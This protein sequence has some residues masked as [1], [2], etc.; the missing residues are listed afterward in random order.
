MKKELLNPRVSVKLRKAESRQEWYIYIEIYPARV[1]GKPGKQ[2]VRKYI[3]RSITTPIW[4]KNQVARTSKGVISYKPKRDRNGIIMC[5]SAIDRESCVYADN[6]RSILQREYDFEDLYYYQFYRNQA[7]ETEDVVGYF[8]RIITER[9]GKKS[10]STVYNFN[11]VYALFKKFVGNKPLRF[12]E[13]D[14]NLVEDFKQYLLYAPKGGKLKGKISKNTASIYFIIFKTMLKQAFI[15]GHLQEDLCSKT[16]GIRGNETHR[17]YLTIEELN[18]LAKAP[19]PNSIIKRAALFSALTGM[20]HCDIK[21]MT[22][23]EIIKGK[24][25]I[26]INFT[27]KKTKGVEY[28]P[29]SMQAYSLCGKPSNPD[30]KV[31]K[32][33]PDPSWICHPLNKWLAASGITK[34]ITFHCFRHT[35]ATLQL[36]NGTDIYTVSKMLGH[37]N[38]KTTQIYTKI[39][40]EKKEQAA[41]AIQLDLDID[42]D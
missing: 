13:V 18:R 5:R 26:H 6:V 39:V 28:I 32:D 9:E 40:D 35:F 11:R 15:D 31:F 38:V 33:L 7:L 23:K 17:E 19:C 12:S 16:K 34:H 22:W 4:N 14:I 8:G 27:Q 24:N 29:I 20:R 37:T 3:H 41:D 10:D 1:E 21:K 30:D 2:R 25:H 42:I 36:A